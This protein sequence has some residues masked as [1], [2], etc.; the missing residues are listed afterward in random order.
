MI[1]S[2]LH[3]NF[4]VRPP[5]LEVSFTWFALI[6]AVVV[7]A[8]GVFFKTPAHVLAAAQRQAAEAQSGDEKPM[9]LR[10]A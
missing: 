10:P 1:F 5:A 7:F 9:A 8:V 4:L 6:G 2:L 3:L